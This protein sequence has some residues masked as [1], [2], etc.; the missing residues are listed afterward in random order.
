M[1][2]DERRD[3]ISRLFSLMTA[4]LE[5]AAALA[6]EGQGTSGGSERLVSLANQVRAGAEE[7]ALLAEVGGMLVSGHQS[8]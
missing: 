7:A 6:A 2:E 1:D 4:K 5:D 3:L 8:A